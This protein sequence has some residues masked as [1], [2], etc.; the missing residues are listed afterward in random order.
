MPLTDLVRQLNSKGHGLPAGRLA[1][2]PFV[3][4]DGRVFGH[5]AN[6]RLE[7]VFLPVTATGSGRVYGHA[8]ALRVFGLTTGTPVSPDA[9]FVLPADDNEF[10]HVDR[11]VRTLHALNYLT[12]RV[13]GTLL[14]HVHRRHVMSVPAD[15]GLAFEE[16]LR[17]C[18]LLPRQITLELDAD[19]VEDNG[20]FARAVANYRQ[21]GY[22]IAFSRFGRTGLDFSLLRSLQPD[23]VKLDPLLLASTRPLERLVDQIHQLGSKVLVEGADRL[24]LRQFGKE[25]R[26]DLLQPRQPVERHPPALRSGTGRGSNVLVTGGRPHL[27]A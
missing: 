6:L 22:G 8:A 23:I 18:G 5:F 12:H 2:D 24:Q 13:R 26:I 1:P 16:I 20:H 3:A 19:G 9:V 15:H 14:L 27:A 10:V 17:P 7:S 11:L 25:A 21:R 4:A